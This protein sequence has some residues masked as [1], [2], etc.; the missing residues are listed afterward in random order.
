MTT[1]TDERDLSWRVRYNPLRQFRALLSAA[2]LQLSDKAVEQAQIRIEQTRVDQQAVWWRTDPDSEVEPT[3]PPQILVESGQVND[4]I[5]VRVWGPIAASSG[6]RTMAS[7]RTYGLSRITDES[8]YT[9]VTDQ[10]LEQIR[11]AAK[12]VLQIVCDFLLVGAWGDPLL[13][14]ELDLALTRAGSDPTRW[15]GR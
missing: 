10:S 7:M 11:E 3:D 6:R 13:R 8:G 2:V 15:E 5:W 4:Q 12:N 1:I 9:A 14:H